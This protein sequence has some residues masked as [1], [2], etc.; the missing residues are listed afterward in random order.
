[1]NLNST[2]IIQCLVFLALAGFTM[3]FVWPPMMRALDERRAKIASGLAA[4]DQGNRS[5][6]DAQVKINALEAEAR[7]R[8]ADIIA[9]TEKRAHALME[10]AKAQAKAEGERLVAA[11]RTE[12][13][14]E[15]RR[16]RLAL[17][18]QVAAL[19]VA[20][21]EKILRR[22]INSQAHAGLLDELKTQL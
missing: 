21:A 22:E 14:Q 8:A 1:M 15:A 5:L 4:A 2:L 9:Q 7:Q 10:E 20:G 6:K 3:K 11:A 13:E 16:A 12:V 18:E 17:R 19:A